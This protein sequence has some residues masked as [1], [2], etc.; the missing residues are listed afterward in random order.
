MDKELDKI[1]KDLNICLKKYN[2]KAYMQE[3]YMGIPL[4]K[5][6]SVSEVI[7]WGLRV[8]EIK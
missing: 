4:A 6:M 7:A 3:D 5:S 8:E 2:L 1:L